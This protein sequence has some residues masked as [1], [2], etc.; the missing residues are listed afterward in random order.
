VIL[1]Q[2]APIFAQFRLH[3]ATQSF[4]SLPDGQSQRLY[5]AFRSKSEARRWITVAP[6]YL[7][8]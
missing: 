4:D 5:V 6:V 3:P 1:R 8:A 7:F 2:S